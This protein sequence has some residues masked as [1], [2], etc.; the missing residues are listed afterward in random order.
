MIPNIKKK[1]ILWLFNEKNLNDIRRI[2][3]MI[4]PKLTWKKFKFQI[5]KDKIKG[6]AIIY[7]PVKNVFVFKIFIENTSILSRKFRFISFLYK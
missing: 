5:K 3:N 6:Q 1:K 2:Q 4:K 7:Y